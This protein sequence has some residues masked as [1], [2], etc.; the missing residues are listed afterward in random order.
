MFGDIRFACPMPITRVLLDIPSPALL[1]KYLLGR[2]LVFF[3]ERPSWRA[4][5]LRFG[6]SRR[7]REHGGDSCSPIDGTSQTLTAPL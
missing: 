7:A 3:S 4:R 6:S 5:E 1:F 2:P